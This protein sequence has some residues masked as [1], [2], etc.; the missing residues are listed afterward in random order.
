MATGLYAINKPIS[1]PI[2]IVFSMR[3]QLPLLNTYITVQLIGPRNKGINDI[4][5]R[6]HGN[7]VSMTV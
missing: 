3:I 6:C 2:Q 4:S 1:S 5:F 7:K